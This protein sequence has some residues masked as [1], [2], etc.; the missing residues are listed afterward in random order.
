MNG[1]GQFL[2]QVAP[3]ILIFILSTVAIAFVFLATTTQDSFTAASSEA[4]SIIGK[5]ISIF[6]GFDNGMA[7]IIL[8]LYAGVVITA[9]FIR[10]HPIF[11]I[12][13]LVLMIFAVIVVAMLANAWE[14]MVGTDAFTSIV[15]SNFPITKTIFQNAPL[16][17]VLGIVV[18][19]VAFY[20]KSSLA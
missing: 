5:V 14:T 20:A 8:S 15:D 11:F 17:T 6:A 4:G 1:K 13:T 19:G 16:L 2:D 18:W 10:S 9:I 3:I 12:I 7:L